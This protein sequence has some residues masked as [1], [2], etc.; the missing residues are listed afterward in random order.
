MPARDSR[1]SA[2]SIAVAMAAWKSMAV[3]KTKADTETALVAQPPVMIFFH[4]VLVS[5]LNQR[6]P[7]NPNTPIFTSELPTSM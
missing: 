2:T 4:V 3:L 7:R 1:R 5:L 6:K